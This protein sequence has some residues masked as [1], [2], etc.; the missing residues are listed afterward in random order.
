MDE[1]GQACR[2]RGSP[3]QGRCPVARQL[4][5]PSEKLARTG[6]WLWLLSV[7]AQGWR[8][9]VEG[10]ALSLPGRFSQANTGM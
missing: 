2:V 10:R 8:T 6:G 1:R 7:Q 9:A 4:H 5:R 3:F